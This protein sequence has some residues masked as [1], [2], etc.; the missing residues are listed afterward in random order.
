MTYQVYAGKLLVATPIIDDD[1][2][3]KQTIVYITE[4]KDEQ[5]FGFVLNKPSTLKVSDVISVVEGSSIINEQKVYMGGPVVQE[6]LFLLH[7]D[8]WY[9]STSKP[10]LN[11]LSV[12]SDHTM[13]QK[14]IDGNLPKNYKLMAGISTWHPR[15]LAMEIHKGGWLVIN[16][17]KPELF[18][19]RDGKQAW[20]KAVQAAG[21]EA[22]DSFF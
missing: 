1:T 6:S 16:D 12:S 13:L 5:V 3:F 21:S 2:T 4:E 22:V 9:S 7:S 14:I 18:F 20:T 19:G 8:E 15:Q 17:P 10:C 11:G